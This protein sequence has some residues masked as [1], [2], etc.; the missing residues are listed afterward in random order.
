VERAREELGGGG[1]ADGAGEADDEAG[2]DSKAR[3]QPGFQSHCRFRNRGTE[4]VSERLV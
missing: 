1:T 3:H 4:Y 2:P